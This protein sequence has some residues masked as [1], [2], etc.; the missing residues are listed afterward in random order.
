MKFNTML[1]TYLL[2]SESTALIALTDVGLALRH[3]VSEVGAG[4]E[5][6]GRRQNLRVLSVDAGRGCINGE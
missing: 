1:A 2:L 4:E 5:V 3:D 6:K